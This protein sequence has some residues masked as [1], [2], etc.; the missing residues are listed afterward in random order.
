VA[1]VRFGVL[2]PLAA[3]DG[4]GLL[5][6][7]GPRHRAVLARLLLAR[8][9]PVPLPLLVADLW[10]HPPEAAAG[11]VQTFVGVLRRALEP[12][13]PARAPAQLLVTVAGGYALRTEPGAVDADRFE[14]GLS[15]SG[16]LLAAGRA[17]EART[18]LDEALALWRG[19]AYTDVADE[20]WARAE[21][22]RLGELRVLALLRR[23][24]AG[25]ATG[26]A[27]EAVA[28]LEAL[29][30]DH[31]MHE[32]AW[33]L[34]ALA[35]YRS[36]RQ[37]DALAA[38]R[39]IRSL[40]REELGAEPGPALRELERDVLAQQP[41]L[42]PTPPR[43]VTSAPAGE[44]FVGREAEL[45]T[46]TD[47]A[48]A[49]AAGRPGLVLVSGAAGAGKTTLTRALGARLAAA[50]WTVAVGASPEVPGAPD[51]WPW[52]QLREALGRA[53]APPAP[54]EDGDPPATRFRYHRAIA[55]WLRSLAARAPVLLVLDDLHWADEETLA[56]LG[57]V[58]AELGT[59]RLL[60]VGTHRSTD[61]SPDLAAALGR[62]ARAEPVRV[63]LGGLSEPETGRLAVLVTGRRPDTG[64]VRA[65]HGRS[66]GNPFLARELLRLWD[67]DGAAALSA[68]PPG[69]RDVLRHR[70]GRLSE[71][72]R[73]HLRQA[74]VQ[75]VDVD[76]DLLIGLA[77][78]ED[79]VLD[80]VEEAL[81]A[82][83]LGE[84][85]AHRLRFAHALVQE[86][87][88]ED[89]PAARRVRWHAVLASLLQESRPDDVEAIAHHLVSA[90]T[91]A[92]ADRTARYARLAAQRA[93][94]RSAPHAAAASWRGAIAALDRLRSAAE[95][96]PGAS[97]QLP[98]AVD[99]LRLEADTGLIRAMALTGDLAGA[100]RQRATALAAAQRLGDPLLTASVLSSSDVPA[101]W[102]TRD[103]EALSDRIVAAAEATLPALPADRRRERARLLV[104]L[105]LER[106][107]DEGP[108]GAEAAREAERIA[109]E[110]DDPALLAF[111]LDGRF[112]QSFSRAGLAPAR[113]RIG[114]ELLAVTGDAPELAAFAVLAR[115]VL[116]QACAARAD[117]AGADAHA[118]AADALA[119]RYAL[120]VVGVFTAWYAALRLAVLGR[121]DEA[122]AAYRSAAARLAGTGMAGLEHG[123]LPLALVSLEV[124]DGRPVADGQHG[125][126][127]PWTRPLVLLGQGDRAGAAAALRTVPRTPHDH[128]LEARDCLLA[129][130]AVEVADLPLAARLYDELLPAADELA[131]AGSGLLTL[132]PVA[133]HLARL[134]TALDRADQAAVHRAQAREVAARAAVGGG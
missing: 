108:R 103:D 119:E 6:L 58:V 127:A 84:R 3:E 82:G 99:R 52:A 92:P 2:G 50:G 80:S 122:R 23:A 97:G 42:S 132:G 38:L 79:G 77:G 129:V 76:L 101:V 93:E 134:A 111:A 120:P 49:A 126:Y 90:G 27:A 40:L 105:A 66:G 94:R 128:L 34:L 96:L 30:A 115:L 48:T 109:R 87:L 107:A 60:V 106:R 78:D 5:D 12:D 83:F 98:G 65:V 26:A 112:L 51:G 133:G 7:R 19:P 131:G 9:R 10:E 86:T 18:A 25:L 64:T 68:V 74:A 20:P 121:T 70:L 31:P 11:A 45:A 116:L 75:G 100:H 4:A 89:A 44:E 53:G 63:Y 24:E 33:R 113:A 85:D 21:V 117:L 88:V 118:A 29:V 35:L 22:L 67:T 28:E 1:R 102:T 56:L 73:T 41:H 8:G 61:I 104:T 95:Q 130:A 55:A 54:T 47:A 72:T 14:A 91:H 110:L 81:L 59:A 36:G 69:V 37:A 123:L 32:E 16:E 124:A 125:P 57:T 13:R 62:L 46:L 43:A 71:R 114:A 15:A 17:Y 39:R